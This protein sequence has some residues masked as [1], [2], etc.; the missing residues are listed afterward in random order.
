[1][2]LEPKRWL[3]AWRFVS[4]IAVDGAHI[5]IGLQSCQTNF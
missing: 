2:S 5:K 1:M 4:F 3:G